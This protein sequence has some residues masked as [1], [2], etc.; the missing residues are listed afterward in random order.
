MSLFEQRLNEGDESI[1][2]GEVWL[3]SVSGK[4]KLAQRHAWYPPGTGRGSRC[5]EGY[6][7]GGRGAGEE[8]SDSRSQTT[9]DLVSHDQDETLPGVDW[10]AGRTF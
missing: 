9:W 2:Q 7:H 5:L 6:N 8:V 1:Q 3:K 4:V 10:G